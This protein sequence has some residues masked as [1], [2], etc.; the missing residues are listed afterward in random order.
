MCLN[1]TYFNWLTMTGG[2]VGQSGVSQR[3]SRPEPEG[4]EGGGRPPEK[5]GGPVGSRK[6]HSN[7]SGGATSH[8]LVGSRGF[9]ATEMPWQSSIMGDGMG[10]LGGPAALAETYRGTRR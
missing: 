4:G 10:W 1:K 2:A 5:R 7:T 8:C 3:S 9:R 6:I